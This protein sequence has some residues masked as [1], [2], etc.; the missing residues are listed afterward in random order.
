MHAFE[1]F[2]K[3]WLHGQSICELLIP[4]E[5]GEDGDIAGIAA[6][7]R[8]LI[9]THNAFVYLTERNISEDERQFRRYLMYLNQSSDLRRISGA[10]R[11][12][13]RADSSW[14]ELGRRH[15]IETL[16]KNRVFAAF[17]AKFQAHLM[18]GQTPYLMNR[19]S[20]PRPIERAIESAVYN[21]FSHNVHS[22]GLASR[23]GGSSTPAGLLNVLF[24]AVEAS[25]VFLASIAKQYRA[26]RARQ[27]ESSPEPSRR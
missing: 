18:R 2:E 23:Y 13:D 11:T 6:L 22:Y 26:L 10:L 20:G 5:R 8:S 12:A 24:L 4:I 25:L 1:L 19:Y 3:A 21:L 7:A 16:E 14:S 15:I 17:D 9:E 27:P